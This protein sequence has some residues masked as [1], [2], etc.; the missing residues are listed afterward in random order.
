[1]LDLMYLL[2][3]YQ[4]SKFSISNSIEMS[5]NISFQALT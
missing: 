1:M 5:Q 2:M 4:I 3:Y